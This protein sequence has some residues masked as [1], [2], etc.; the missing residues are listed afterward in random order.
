M[1]AVGVETEEQLEALR[2]P[3]LRPGPG[4][5]V[6]P[7]AAGRPGGR[8][9]RRRPLLTPG[10]S[11]PRHADRDRTVHLVA[12]MLGRVTIDVD[13]ASPPSDAF[14]ALFNV[15]DLGGY[16]TADG[17]TP[18]GGRSTGPTGSTA[19]RATTSTGSRRSVCAPCST[20]APTASSS[21]RGSFPVDRL[22]VAYHHLPV[23]RETWEGWDR[24]SRSRGAVLPGPALPRDARRGRG[25]AGRRA[26]GAGRRPMPIRPCST[27][28]P[29]RTAPACWPRSS[30]AL[31]G[32]DD[33]TIA[34]D[35]GLSRAGMESLV[36][37][38]RTNV[39]EAL[40]AM[41]DQPAVLPRRATAGHA[42]AA[43]R[44]AGRVRLDG[45]LRRAPSVSD[46]DV[47][48]ALRANLLD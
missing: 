48:D 23:L 31:L 4:L 2:H 47:V 28:P 1:I 39:P 38:M 9:R 40:D 3:R 19:P 42:R 33:D 46:A 5:P 44:G 17:R 10:R 8:S 22:P 15:R 30:S 11:R 27:A 35:Y 32:V 36:E 45:R 13:R 6:R 21:E 34:V 16:R 24:R 37:W 14:D 7:A 41:T 18:G 43:G 25:G 26:R 12:G 20:C 29:A